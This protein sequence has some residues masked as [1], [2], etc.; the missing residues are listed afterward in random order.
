[1][2][3]KKT[4]VLLVGSNPLPNYLAAA[5][6]KP[7]RVLLLYTPETKPPKERLVHALHDRL[8][9][10]TI[11]I[12]G[13]QV[14]DAGSAKSV[15]AACKGKF[16]DAHLNYTGGTKVMAAIARLVFREE[17]GLDVDAS[18][19]DERNGLLRFDGDVPS[20]PL[21][22][23]ELGL[24]VILAL[25]DFARKP[26]SEALP[27]DPTPR[28]AET[29]ARWC[30]EEPT[31]ATALYRRVSRN[32]ETKAEPISYK[33]FADAP[34][35]EPLQVPGD[36]WSRKAIERWIKFLRGPWQELWAAEVMRT[37]AGA[38]AALHVGVNLSRNK[39]DTEL[40][41]LMIRGHRL[42]LLSCT[43]DSTPDL[44]KLKLFEA[45]WRARQ[46]GGDLACCALACL[47]PAEGVAKVRAD[48]EATWGESNPPTLFGLDELGAWIGLH[49]APDRTS[50]ATWM[51]S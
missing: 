28:D 35:T 44:C 9:I 17:K 21:A 14:E 22:T 19:V 43:T 40:D 16:A 41:V 33:E 15:R 47:L 12:D 34:L 24:D 42:Y 5:T 26:P 4:L 48:V 31:R 3:G 38:E 39:R 7:A 20:L 49:S 2:N 32:L 13:A 36:E 8:Q 18:Y 27:T 11:D 45:T 51:K 37:L 23:D 10:P 1:V 25:H 46:V 6:L 50:L 29:M 30:L